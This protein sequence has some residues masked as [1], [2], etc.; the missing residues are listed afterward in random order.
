MYKMPQSIK[1][2]CDYWRTG[3]VRPALGL[4]RLPK[5]LGHRRVKSV[6]CNEYRL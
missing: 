5:K 4:A 3:S 2:Q 1:Q 6:G